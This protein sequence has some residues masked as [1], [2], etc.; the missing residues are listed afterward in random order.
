MR[1]ERLAQDVALF[2][3]PF[4][5]GASLA[6]GWA[7][8][9]PSVTLERVESAFEDVTSATREARALSRD[10]GHLLDA[11]DDVRKL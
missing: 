10:I 9:R 3:L 8:V 6:A 11:A 1:D 4:V 5:G 7:T 2:A